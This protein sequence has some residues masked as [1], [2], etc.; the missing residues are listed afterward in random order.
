MLARRPDALDDADAFVPEDHVLLAKQKVGEAQA[1]VRDLDDD[2]VRVE[3]PV[4]GRLHDSAERGAFEDGEGGD[5]RDL[6]EQRH[7]CYGRGCRVK[8]I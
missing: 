1:R 7:T 8:E 2:G 5:P 4:R 3:R 6:V